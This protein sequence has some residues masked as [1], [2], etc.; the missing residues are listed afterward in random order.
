MKYDYIFAGA[1]LAGLMVLNEMINAD[2]LVDKNV[3]ILDVDPKNKNDRTWC[4]WEEGA[5][6]WDFILKKEWD[7]ALF[8][9]NINTIECL[10][11][12]MKYKMIESLSFY[13]TI[14]DKL[15]K[16][17]KITW[18]QEKIVSFEDSENEVLVISDKEKYFTSILFNSVFDLEKIKNNL[19]YP[20]LQQHF[21]GWFI[22]TKKPFFDSGCV[23][24]MDFSIP[25][26]N[27]TRFMYVLPLSETEALLE[28]TLF[29][30]DLL[31]ENEYESAISSYIEN[32]G[33]VDFEIM[34]KERGNIPMT[35]YPFWNSNSKNV[36]H[37]G[38][39]G[40]WTKASTGYTFKNTMKQ[41]KALIQF[42]K[43]ENIDFNAFHKPNRFLFF[44]KLFIKVLYENNAL[45]Y[46]LFS[47][48]FSKV[49]PQIVFR[50][51]DE[52]S[53][54]FEDLK[55]ILSCP[56]IPF[57]KALFRIKK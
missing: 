15:K 37:I 5:G 48:M 35:A 3:L 38:T 14:M 11:G 20:L 51:L 10:S 29:S 12:G 45:G 21:I 30:P 26:K 34:E 2:L 13:T 50:F 27:N 24:F 41:S 43:R 9:N 55:V 25:Q 33:I 1:G 16:H 52:K 4:F 6:E 28:Y 49:N 7:R 39:A 22:K 56:K 44:D 18:K 8:I 46:S 32:K 47:R 54:L 36:L 42:L 31:E 23:T 53:T 19:E 17:P 57:I 40:G